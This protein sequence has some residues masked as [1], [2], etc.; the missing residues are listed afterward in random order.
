MA[1]AGRA[2]FEAR[3]VGIGREPA[4]GPRRADIHLVEFPEGAGHVIG[5]TH[6]AVIVSSDRLNRNSGTV[7]LCP[8]TS[9]SRHD[10]ASYLPPYLVAAPARASG[11]D[12]DGFVKADR[13][14]TRA[15]ESLGKKIGRL[16]PE[17]MA[18]VDVALGFV[19]EI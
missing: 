19:L 11:L 13:V 5:G 7:L 17:T 12:R 2:P 14:F 10:A 15:V 16:N 1:D 3:V 18:Q 6:P 9:R 8:M 4:G